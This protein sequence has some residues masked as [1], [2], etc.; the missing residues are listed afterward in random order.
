MNAPKSAGRIVRKTLSF[1]RGFTRVPNEWARD[2]NLSFRAIGILTH[3]MSHEAGWSITMRDLA[4]R[5]KET[6]ETSNEGLSACR[7]AVNELE[8]WGYVERDQVIGKNG[9]FGAVQWII[10][11]P[12]EGG[13]R[14][15]DKSDLAPMVF[16]EEVNPQT[17]EILENP[18]SEPAC[19]LPS[20]VQPTTAEP[21]TAQPTTAQPTTGDR[22]TTEEHL[23]QEHSPQDQRE[24]TPTG[25]VTNVSTRA[26]TANFQEAAALNA[27]IVRARCSRSRSGRHLVA[28]P[29]SG[30]C[31]NCGERVA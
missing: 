26:R 29:A 6:H 4:N 20:S 28:D 2:K 13:R 17:G 25:P 24:K 30:Y 15:V 8:R 9:R 21:T 14:P 10:T 1:E 3:L 5:S 16:E 31:V 12:W 22:T 7:T 19:D 11:D 27:D 23:P 18:S